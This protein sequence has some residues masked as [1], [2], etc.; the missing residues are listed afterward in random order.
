MK[1]ILNGNIFKAGS[2]AGCTVDLFLY[3]I[4]TIKTR[5]QQQ[6]N[7][8]HKRFLFSSLYSGVGSAMIGSGPSSA[9][10]FLSYNLTKQTLDLSSSSQIHMIAA[11]CGEIVCK[12]NISLK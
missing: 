5:L 9:L 6:K 2:I 3:P 12:S 1:N 10:F 11:A 7:N 4:D 8:V